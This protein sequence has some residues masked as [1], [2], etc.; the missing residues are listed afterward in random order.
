MEPFINLKKRGMPGPKKENND[1]LGLQLV[2]TC[3][4]PIFL[5]Q[6]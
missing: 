1:E 6:H 2:Y 5:P 4:F 3:Y